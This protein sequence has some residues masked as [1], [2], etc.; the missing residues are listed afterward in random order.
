MKLWPRGY[1]WVDCH[2][3]MLLLQF[4][5]VWQVKNRCLSCDRLLN[6]NSVSICS[7]EREKEKRWGLGRERRRKGELEEAGRRKAG[8]ELLCKAARQGEGCS[9]VSCEQKLASQSALSRCRCHI[10]PADTRHNFKLI[11]KYEQWRGTCVV[12]YS[13]MLSNQ[14]GSCISCTV[15]VLQRSIVL[16]RL[17]LCRRL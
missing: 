4:W 8:C 17:V 6:V 10:T 1:A 7:L 5:P 16:C 2:T 3:N 12:L 13:G 15:P 14:P 11:S 9:Q